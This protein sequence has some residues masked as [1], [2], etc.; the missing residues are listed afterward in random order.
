MGV[1]WCFCEML[2]Y[3]QKIME[4]KGA[5]PVGCLTIGKCFRIVGCC[6]LRLV[7][8]NISKTFDGL[9]V[10]MTGQLCMP[11][12]KFVLKGEEMRR[13]HNCTRRVLFWQVG[14]TPLTLY[15]AVT[16]FIEPQKFFARSVRQCIEEI[17]RH[18][19]AKSILVLRRVAVLASW[20]HSPLPLHALSL[21][22]ATKTIFSPSEKSS[23]EESVRPYRSSTFKLQMNV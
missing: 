2:L 8:R 22:W 7:F 1:G 11:R 23:T 21:Y 19:L 14:R 5:T 18:T 4:A 9:L 20:S 16:C 10:L 13:G 12:I 3:L 15:W 17:W 6:W